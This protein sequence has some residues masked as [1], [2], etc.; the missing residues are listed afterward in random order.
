[1]GGLYENNI[2]SKKQFCPYRRQ[3]ET[4]TNDREN[5]KDNK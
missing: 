1:M 5:G 3:K 2:Y 4:A